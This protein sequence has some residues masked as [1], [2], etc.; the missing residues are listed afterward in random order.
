MDKLSLKDIRQLREWVDQ[1]YWDFERMSRSGQDT[2]NKIAN[3]LGLQ[4]HALEEVD[5]K[6]YDVIDT[7][8]VAKLQKEIIDNG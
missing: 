5:P 6:V 7:M 3:R 8:D 2:L 4:N 1:M